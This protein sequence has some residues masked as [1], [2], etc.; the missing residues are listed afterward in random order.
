MTQYDTVVRINY[1]VT[2]A[3]RPHDV[4][5]WYASCVNFCKD[6]LG[7]SAWQVFT[8]AQFYKWLLANGGKVYEASDYK[9]IQETLDG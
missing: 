8:P 4:S 7:L 5:R 2:C 9:R 3:N 1:F 6:L